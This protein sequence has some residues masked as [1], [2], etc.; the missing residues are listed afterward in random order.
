MYRTSFFRF[1]FAGVNLPVFMDRS[2]FS[3]TGRHFFRVPI[4][5]TAFRLPVLISWLSFTVFRVPDFVLR[6]YFAGVSRPAFMDHSH[7]LL[8]FIYWR[9][10]S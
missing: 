4:S 7:A 5:F 1:S 10:S 9:K 8:F 6:F 3:F 2:H